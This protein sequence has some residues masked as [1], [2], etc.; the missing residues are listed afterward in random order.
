[1]D[2]RPVAGETTFDLHLDI[3]LWMQ[4]SV[5]QPT[6]TAQAPQEEQETGL[7]NNQ[8]KLRIYAQ[9]EQK[10]WRV[11]KVLLGHDFERSEET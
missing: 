5:A 10:I 2:A 4:R 6:L 11:V 7:D 9:L 3:L 1:M 8:L